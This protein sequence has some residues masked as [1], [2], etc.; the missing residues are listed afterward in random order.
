MPIRSH[1]SSFYPDFLLK[2]QEVNYLQQHNAH[3]GAD[4][5][6]PESVANLGSAMPPFTQ[7][8]TV[9]GAYLAGRYAQRHFDW[10]AAGSFIDQVLHQ[11]PNDPALIKR[12]M[13]LAMGAGDVDQAIALAKRAEEAEGQPSA[14]AELFMAV[15]DFKTKNYQ[16]ASAHIEKMP[17]GGLSDFILPLL[18]SWCSVI[19][20]SI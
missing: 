10:S 7:A 4:G 20:R 13:V 15:G 5:K 9:S 11:T 19:V 14:L 17:A 8:S 1:G 18:K 12:A 16:S 6:P 3:Q 2:W